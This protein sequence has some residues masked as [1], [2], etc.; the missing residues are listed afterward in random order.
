MRIP[1]KITWEFLYKYAYG[2]KKE[3]TDSIIYAQQG[4]YYLGF[5]RQGG[6][7]LFQ[8]TDWSQNI[9]RLRKNAP[10]EEIFDIMQQLKKS[11]KDK[12][13]NLKKIKICD[14]ENPKLKVRKI[15]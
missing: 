2:S 15:K 8:Y 13:Y 11:E 1:K 9:I 10:Y 5:N 14:C 4:N 7:N 3:V 6:I 12:F